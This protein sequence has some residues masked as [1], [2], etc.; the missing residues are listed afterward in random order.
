[1]KKINLLIVVFLILLMVVASFIEKNK[2]G[3]IEA[4]NP[5]PMNKQTNETESLLLTLW[6]GMTKATVKNT[7]SNTEPLIRP[8]QSDKSQCSK[9][10]I[11]DEMITT[12]FSS[13][14]L[15]YPC[16]ATSR[17][18]VYTY[19]DEDN[20]PYKKFS[21]Y[22]GAALSKTDSSIW[23]QGPEDNSRD[24]MSLLIYLQGDKTKKSIPSSAKRMSE[25]FKR[26]E[27]PKAD[28]SIYRDRARVV[29]YLMTPKDAIG[30]SPS[31]QCL[32]P[33]DT[34][35][36]QIFSPLYGLKERYPRNCSASWMLAED[37]HVSVK[38]IKMHSA[39]H[40]N[41]IYP[42]INSALKEILT[43]Q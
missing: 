41:E 40:F 33:S 21:L 7:K 25:E 34:N 28:I 22:L 32:M 42:Q 3:Q 14:I 17:G 5:L 39:Y 24:K 19:F 13:Y 30:H 27:I 15:K 20:K 31:I 1:M 18:E 9:R 2:R 26:Y 23:R 43:T 29:G 16:T 37:I 35:I 10:P 36:E 38:S 8:I 12:K 11:I 4:L 6:S